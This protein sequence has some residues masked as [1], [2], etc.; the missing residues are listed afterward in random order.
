LAFT[1]RAVLGA[2]VA[3]PVASSS[4]GAERG[5]GPGLDCFPR[6]AAGV[7]ITEWETTLAA[8]RKAEAEIV[9]FGRWAA[10]PAWRSFEERE[11]LE[12]VYGERVSA[13]DAAM[14]RLLETPA[15]DVGAMA[16]KIGLIAAQRVWEL[17]GGEECL[18]ILRSD[19]ERLALAHSRCIRYDAEA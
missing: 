9:E 11:A 7:A 2:A 18:S 16:L 17:D 6:P 4:R 3:V 8:L 12:D 10:S 14:L 5:G 15:P 1:R 13:F 19:A